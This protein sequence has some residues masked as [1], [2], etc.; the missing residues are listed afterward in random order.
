MPIKVLTTESGVQQTINP[1]LGEVREIHS[2]MTLLICFGW[3]VRCFGEGK[4]A[5]YFLRFYSLWIEIKSQSIPSRLRVFESFK[6][7]EYYFI[8]HFSKLQLKFCL[9]LSDLDCSLKN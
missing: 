6:S 7:I 2:V 1:C 4:A 5:L 3:F 9:D 8:N